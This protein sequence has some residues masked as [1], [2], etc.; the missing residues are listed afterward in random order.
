MRVS[1]VGVLALSTAFLGAGFPMPMPSMIISRTGPVGFG[2]R[3][4]FSSL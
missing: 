3:V 4:D 1:N 2:K